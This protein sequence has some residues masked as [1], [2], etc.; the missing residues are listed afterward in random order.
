M[1]RSFALFALLTIAL[2]CASAT[3]T[4]SPVDEVAYPS[5]M[6][7]AT[8]LDEYRYL[9]GPGSARRA[10]LDALWQCAVRELPRADWVLDRRDDSRRVA[11]FFHRRERVE[12]FAKVDTVAALGRAQVAFRA[13]WLAPDSTRVRILSGAPEWTLLATSGQRLAPCIHGM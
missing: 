12:L 4:P 10:T 8:D 7:T 9:A 11:R 1:R 3:Q 6:A 13:N 5:A 2:A